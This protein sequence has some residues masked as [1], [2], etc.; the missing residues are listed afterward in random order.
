MASRRSGIDGPPWTRRS[1]LPLL[2][3]TVAHRSLALLDPGPSSF[4]IVHRLS[5]SWSLYDDRVTLVVAVKLSLPLV[6]TL[7]HLLSLPVLA[8][9]SAIK[10]VY[11]ASRDSFYCGGSGSIFHLCVVDVHAPWIRER[12]SGWWHD[13]DYPPQRTSPSALPSTPCDAGVVAPR[14]G[15]S[16]STHALLDTD[17]R[18]SSFAPSVLSGISYDERV[19]PLFLHYI[20]RISFFVYFY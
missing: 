11:Y 3:S 18:D 17:G 19:F 9:R 8:C 15:R 5:S 16:S 14:V 10:Q 13:C 20:N 12:A 1:L 7:L 4:S 6:S 2:L